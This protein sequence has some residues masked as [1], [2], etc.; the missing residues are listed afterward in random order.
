MG[1][2]GLCGSGDSLVLSTSQVKI[3]TVGC[4]HPFPDGGKDH[5]PLGIQGK[6]YLV[7]GQHFPLDFLIKGRRR[8]GEAHHPGKALFILIGHGA[9]NEDLPSQ[10]NIEGQIDGLILPQGLLPCLVPVPVPGI[11]GR[12]HDLRGQVDEVLRSCQ[13]IHAQA[14]TLF[15]TNVKKQWL[16]LM[17]LC[18][19]L[20]EFPCLGGPQS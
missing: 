3:R 1:Q 17:A 10:R 7:T 14:P 4:Q 19:A 8:Q 9:V 5:L 13:E 16:H 20:Y 2:H 15:G 6:G 18:K 12:R 11:I